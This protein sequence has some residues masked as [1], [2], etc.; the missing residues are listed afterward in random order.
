M[1]RTLLSV[2]FDLD[3]AVDADFDF[4]FDREGHGFSRA[5][6]E[7]PKSTRLQ[8][9]RAGLAVGLA[10]RNRKRPVCPHITTAYDY[11]EQCLD[12]ADSCLVIGYSFRDYD[13]LM[14]FKSAK[15]SNKHLKI[16][17]LDPSAEAICEYL[18][19]HGI[20]A[21]PISYALGGKQE[22]EYLPLITSGTQP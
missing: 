10:A 12:K 20:S 7:P 18:K 22:S 3:V 1:G 9:L 19:S 5:E 8:P 4:D 14:R 2:A 6:I 16:A 17:V 15:L 11:L 21:F 13:T